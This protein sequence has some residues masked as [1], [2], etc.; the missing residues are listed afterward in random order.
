MKLNLS[1]KK[2]VVCGER[3]QEADDAVFCPICGAPHH[4][5]CYASLGHC[6]LEAEH[7]KKSETVQDTAEETTCEPTLENDAP[8]TVQKD[9]EIEKKCVNCGESIPEDTRFCPFCGLPIEE[10]PFFK[11]TV[12]EL[13]TFDKNEVIAEG[14]TAGD[15]ARVVYLNPF[16]YI[17]CFKKLGEKRRISW[18]WAAFLVPGG[19]LAYRKMYKESFAATALLITTMLFN[20][21]FNLAVAANLPISN[22]I[23]LEEVLANGSDYLSAIGVLPVIM[24]FVGI[25]LRLVIHL[26]VAVFGD[27]IYKNRVIESVKLIN[28]SDEPDETRA[29]LSGVS[30]FA[31]IIAICAL[32]FLPSIISILIG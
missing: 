25:A 2:C 29:K 23:G 4:R 31:F 28:E 15:A 27:Y 5:E 14:V 3:F 10:R 30:F 32:E 18:N 12:Y 13:P 26:F 20:L 1:D 19:W 17:A 7:G 9:E 24:V 16:R 21:P 22:G 8:S 11:T 6:G